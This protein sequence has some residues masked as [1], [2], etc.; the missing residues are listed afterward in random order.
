MKKLLLVLG[1]L[2]LLT[3]GYSKQSGDSKADVSPPTKLIAG[4]WKPSWSPDGLQIVY[5]KG[6]GTGLERFE[7]V[8]RQSTPLI[9]GGKDACWSPNGRWVAFVREESYNNYLTE[10]V[11]VCSDEGIEPHKLVTGGFPSWSKDGKKLFV[12][13]RERNE[14]LAVNPDDPKANPVVFFENTPSWY[15]SVSPD[16]SRIAFGCAGRLE[17]RDRLTG[18]VVGRWPTPED[19][20]LL[21]AWSPDGKLVAFG[22]FDASELGI[23]VLDVSEMKAIRLMEGHC[24]MPAWKNDGTSLAF[25]TRSGNRAVWTVGRP[26]I[27]SKLVDAKSAQNEI[28]EEHQQERPRDTG[29]LEGKAAPDFKL[30]SLD[31][32]PVLLSQFKGNI[33]VLDFWAT[34]CPPCRKSLPHVQEVSHDSDL[35]KK[36]LRILAIDLRETKDQVQTFLTNNSY[37]FPVAM[38]ND[39]AVAEKYLVQGIPTTV[40]IDRKGVVQKVWIGFGDGSAKMIDEAITDLISRN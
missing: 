38:D 15:F 32:A 35:G 3:P 39:G 19:R 16:E 33:L 34:W 2:A 31:G 24:T 8:S 17:I 4:G 29:A 30:Q 37:N 40:I 14:V 26:F 10:E 21:P 6:E 25:D 22:G 12:H 28:A 36:G 11:W 23:W 20:G 5:G 7:I 9:S 13:S 1:A 27:E 18:K